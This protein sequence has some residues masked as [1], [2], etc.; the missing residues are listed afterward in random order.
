MMTKVF[1]HKF[2][3]F[4][5]YYFFLHF[6]EYDLY[7][8]LIVAWRL[9]PPIWF[10]YC[11]KKWKDIFF[12]HFILLSLLIFFYL[13]KLKLIKSKWQAKSGVEVESTEIALAF[14]LRPPGQKKDSKVLLS[15]L[16]G[17]AL[18]I[19]FCSIPCNNVTTD[20]QSTSDS[21]L[22]VVNCLFCSL[23]HPNNLCLLSFLWGVMDSDSLFKVRPCTKIHNLQGVIK[24]L[25][26]IFI[27]P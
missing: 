22:Y 1:P 17:Y 12:N 20:L 19:L 6:V 18:L 4:T 16:Q 2:I 3:Y 8:S 9:V 11:V 27:K 21:V 13:F 26:W 25:C 15:G 7:N 14:P 10:Q 24:S 5:V 23:F